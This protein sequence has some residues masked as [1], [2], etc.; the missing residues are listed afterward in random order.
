MLH[1]GNIELPKMPVF[2]APMENITDHSFRLLCKE[3]GADMVYSEFI[4]SEGLIRNI[5][6][7][8][9]KINISEKEMPAGIQLY[10]HNVEAL[11][12]SVKIAEMKKPALID[13][14]FG[15]P[16]KKIVNHGDGAAL[17]KDIPLMAKLTR[18]V[19]NST[20][21]PVTVKTRL[22]WDED[23][24]N[25]VEVVK[26]LQD[27]GIA[28]I[29]IHGR[30]RAQL[31]S[32]NADWTLIGE[33]KNNPA[34]TIPV[35]GNGD[36]NS[37]EKA[38]HAFGQYGVDAIMIGRAAI[39]TPWLF[40]QVKHYLTTGEQLPAPGVPEKSNIAKQHLLNTINGK[41]ELHGIFEMR[42]HLNSYFKGLP[43][44]K[45][46][47]LELLTSKDPG[48]ICDILDSIAERYKDY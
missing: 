8:L 40:K 46:T 39:G 36:I 1:I 31:Y 26:I 35:I 10:G 14:N 7:I 44:F 28:A 20:K 17:L 27:T 5:K 12:E 42:R 11:V 9:S 22:G 34:I 13:L 23:T 6:A 48:H 45:Q 37:P 24:K 38:R 41:G 2:L 30:T 4:A 3:F 33:V 47:R 18:A 25:I 43:N 19:V 32:G 15:C 29:T 21:L 16:V